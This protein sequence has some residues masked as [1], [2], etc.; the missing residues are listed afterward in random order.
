MSR[1][2]PDAFHVVGRLLHN[3]KT[4][5]LDLARA[6]IRSLEAWAV[7]QWTREA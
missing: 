3:P 4:V 6:A 2:M 7:D 1:R 5:N